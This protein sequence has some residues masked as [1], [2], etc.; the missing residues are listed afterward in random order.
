MRKSLLFSLMVLGAM[1][2]QAAGDGGSADAG[3]LALGRTVSADFWA[4]K[5][6]PVWTRMSPVMQKGLDGNISGLATVREKL[7]AIAAGPGQLVSESVQNVSG[8][9]VYLRVFRVTQGGEPA[10][11]QEQWA[12]QDG[13]TVTGFYVRPPSM[14]L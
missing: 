7:L 12:I 8:N 1:N 3:A 2:S 6:E 14:F 9:V 10:L 4:G 5:L 13:R 11:F